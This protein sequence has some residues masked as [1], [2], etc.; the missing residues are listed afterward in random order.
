LCDNSTAQILGKDISCGCPVRTPPL[1]QQ[2]I[3]N[4]Q[5]SK[6]HNQDIKKHKII[7]LF[8]C[9]FVL[10]KKTKRK[11]KSPIIDQKSNNG[12]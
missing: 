2:Y 7:C 1:P 5:N 3:H 9:L 10:E 4:N 12:I 8:V 11:K 6:M